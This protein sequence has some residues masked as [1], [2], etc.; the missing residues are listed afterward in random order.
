MGWPNYRGD[1]MSEQLGFRDF[2]WGHV[3]D[4]AS[5]YKRA[6]IAAVMGVTKPAVSILLRP[7]S[8]PTLATVDKLLTAM[9]ILDEHGRWKH[10]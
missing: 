8:N 7:D 10:P 6:D 2:V 9:N 1:I 4:R 3:L 5:K